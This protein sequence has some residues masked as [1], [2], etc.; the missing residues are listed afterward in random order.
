M[1]E[2]AVTVLC[3]G[4]GGAR[5]A[6]AFRDAGI[7]ARFVTNVGDDVEVDGLLVCPDTDAVLHALAGCFDE[8]RGWGVRGDVFPPAPGGATPWFNVGHRDRAHHERRA[9]LLSGDRSLS[10]ATAAL[11]AELAVPFPVVPVTDDPVRTRIRTADGW[12]GW[13]EW[14]VRERAEPPVLAI[15]HLGASSA[16]PAAGVV[17]A[18]R[19]AAL[20]VLAPS[21]PLASLA[22]IVA[23]PGVGEALWRR[24]GPT[25]A[26]SPVVRRRPLRTDRD[27]HRARAR[28]ALL[29]AA[30]IQHDPVAVAGWYVGL[31]DTFVLDRADAADAPLVAD[32]G[33]RVLVEETVGVRPSLARTVAT[34]AATGAT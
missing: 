6:L 11:A 19:D 22:P 18:V 17:E 20:V 33:F 10:E 14:L 13:Q 12:L 23:V 2:P 1:T 15:E 26:I 3:G 29:A 16:R 24:S 25:V 28:A 31:A 5:L 30:G 8:E 27:R 7:P 32:R 9:A 21:S 4:L 34:L